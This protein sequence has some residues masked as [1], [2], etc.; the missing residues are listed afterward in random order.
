MAKSVLV[1]IGRGWM[2]ELAMVLGCKVSNFL[3]KH[4]GLSLGG[5][6]KEASLW[7]RVVTWE[8][9]RLVGRENACSRVVLL[10]S[11]LSNLLVYFLSLLYT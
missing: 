4:L 3:L 6:I 5:H 11:V 9:I 1:T 8:N 7:D 10:N 2:A